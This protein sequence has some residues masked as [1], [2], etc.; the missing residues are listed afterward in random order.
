MAKVAVTGGAG[1]IGSNLARRLEQRGHELRIIDD[2]STGLRTNLQDLDCRI[3]DFS[4]L[5]VEALD[6]SLRGCDWVFH[7]GARGSVP[8]SIK[9]PRATFDVN[10]MGTLNVLTLARKH[11]LRLLF[12]SSSS[13][14]G[15]NNQI[16][17][18]EVS[19]TAPMSPYAASKLSAEALVQGFS[20][21]FDLP[22][23]TFRLFNVFG[24]LQRPDHDYAAVIPRWIW[25]TMKTQCIDV[26][27]DGNQSRDFTYIDSVIDVFEDTLN[28]NFDYP[29]PVN[30]AF[31][32]NITLKQIID[33][34]RER[35]PDLEVKFR[36]ERKGDVRT[37][38]N[39][40][41]L[42]NKLFPKVRPVAFKEGLKRTH[43]WLMNLESPQSMN[44]NR[45]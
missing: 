22:F 5:D 44:A 12:S 13:V 43:D 18:S 14:Y 4:I 36:A 20:S 16:P 8:R 6:K 21:A 33:F 15:H 10:A 38:Q 3:F 19:W 39:D 27:G 37:S 29:T 40:P 30:L 41:T 1:F 32:N 26:F 42:I 25:Q 17:K 28:R 7:L 45:L 35:Y 34:L 2:F 31:G 11:D 23:V 24:P 9:E